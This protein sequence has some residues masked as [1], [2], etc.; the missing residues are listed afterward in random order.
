MAEDRNQNTLSI[1]INIEMLINYEYKLNEIESLQ[2][3]G[4]AKKK[5]VIGE[6]QQQKRGKSKCKHLM[7]PKIGTS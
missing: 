2:A 1:S 5:E 7:K 4:L 3:I 6:C